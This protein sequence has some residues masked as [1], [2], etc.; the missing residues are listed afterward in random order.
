MQSPKFLLGGYFFLFAMSINE[1]SAQSTSSSLAPAQG[2]EF[3]VTKTVKAKGK[4][5]AFFGPKKAKAVKYR[6]GNVKHSAQYEFYERVERAAREKQKIMKILARRQY[7]DPSY[8]GHKKKPKRRP[9]HK[10]RLCDECK[11]RH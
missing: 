2:S 1:I 11:I 8:F 3:A 10:M 6:R 5:T 9:P 7:S 4:K